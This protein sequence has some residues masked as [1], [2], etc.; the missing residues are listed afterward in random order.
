VLTTELLDVLRDELNIKRVQFLQGAGDL[1]SLRAQPNFR[2]L[3]KRFGGQTQEAAQQIRALDGEALRAF[4][5]GETVSIEVAGAQQ[6]LEPGDL[7][8]IEEAAGDLVVETDEGC[9]IALDPTVDN[10]LRLE[11]LARELV[12]RIQRVRKDTGLAVS[13]RIRLGIFGGAD[14]AAA[15]EAHRD[16]IAAETLAS[17]LEVAG[18]SS[19]WAGSLHDV[20]LDGVAVRIGIE[21]A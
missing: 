14:V 19:G 1:V 13:D 6:V 12:N 8:V 20:D 7:E 3:G 5:R 15:V 4:V 18:G 2:Q 10:V 21:R 11:G 16:H 17:A 9:T